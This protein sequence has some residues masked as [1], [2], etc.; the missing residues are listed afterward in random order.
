MTSEARVTITP[1]LVIGIFIMLIGI[2]LTLD[3][4][5]ILNAAYSL[6]L[7]PAVLVVLGTWMV[8]QRHDAKGRFWG[9]IWIL[10][11]AWLLLNTIGVVQVGFWE[12]VW[13]IAFIW[14]GLSLIR[15]TLGRGSVA[16]TNPGEAG[17]LFD[18]IQARFTPRTEASGTVALFAVMGE[19]KRSISGQEFRSGEMTA[20]MGGCF[21]D[22]RQATMAPGE[23]ATIDVFALM[24]GHEIWVPTGWTV[25][26]HVVPFMGNVDDK[27]L[28]AAEGAAPTLDARPRLTLR[29]FVMM[30]GLTIKS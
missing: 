2:L 25:L 26:S 3:R 24:A 11:G 6:R 8:S 13:P 7:W 1:Q 18:W 16:R 4:L 30:G 29:G 5:H 14:L 12:L 15:Q 9:T 28:P 27:R 17:G 23:Q 10:V 19:S 22:L 21:L 20:I